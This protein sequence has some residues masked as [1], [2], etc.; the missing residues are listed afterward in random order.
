MKL[1]HHN[2][3]Y[4]KYMILVFAGLG[5]PIWAAD[6]EQWHPTDLSFTTTATFANPFKDVTLDAVFTGPGNVTLKIPGFYVGANTWKIRFAPTKVGAWTYVTSSPD[7][8]LGNVTGSVNCVANTQANVH[9]RLAVDAANPHHFRFEDGAPFFLMG[10][11][12]DWLALINCNDA[13]LAKPKQIVDMY[14]AQGFTALNIFAYAWDTPWGNSGPEDYGPPDMFAW[15]GTNANP[16]HTRLNTAFWDHYD[17]VI[18][19]L[20]Q[21][22][23]VAYIYFKDNNKGVNNPAN[24]SS[25][26]S[27]RFNNIV[28]RYQAYPNIV[29]CFMKESY[30]EPDHAY[31][32]KMMNL[33]TANDAYKRLRTTHDDLGRGVDYAADPN[34]NG[35]LDFRTDQQMTGLYSTVMG[36]HNQKNW[37]VYNT[38]LGYEI[39]NDGG[40]TYSVVNSKEEVLARFYEVLMAGGYPGYYY[41]YHAWDVV[42][43]AEVPNGLKFYGY[44]SHFFTA[45]SKWYETVPNDNL[46][47]NKT[48]NHC[49][50]KAGSEYLVYLSKGGS[51]TLT[52]AGV[53]GQ[54]NGTW[55]NAYTGQ[56]QSAGPFGSGAANLTAPWPN[57][58]S[59]LWLGNG[60]TTAVHPGLGKDAPMA[61]SG[62][63]KGPYRVDIFNLQ[64]K[65][66]GS[67]VSDRPEV[68]AGDAKNHVRPGVYW[69]RIRGNTAGSADILR[70]L[71]VP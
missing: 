60:P 69:V 56:E 45:K 64:G 21:K 26:D 38:E 42:K 50:A 23:I 9:G 7:S 29:W 31:I 39:G 52:L 35:N 51:T 40:H 36:Q 12:I 58:P 62:L 24:G 18:D 70:K 53:T 63:S 57:V 10:G 6:V 17:K 32:H 49:L 27:L 46:L 13:T 30:N 22:G 19:Y 65:S 16:D 25:N 48:G 14:A 59:L 4:L 15:A 3:C 8:K 66:A 55:M 37:P 44:L 43:T 41:T 71:S 61:M 28:T 54:L 67:F 47:G 34:L 1:M 11:E 20:F 33:I 68:T 5:L 2:F